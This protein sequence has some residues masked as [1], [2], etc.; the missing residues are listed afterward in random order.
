MAR[1]VQFVTLNHYKNEFPEEPLSE[2]F[3]LNEYSNVILQV[4]ST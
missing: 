3:M 4:G 1:S 2:S